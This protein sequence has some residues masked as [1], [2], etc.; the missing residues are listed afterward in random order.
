MSH[1]FY[2]DDDEQLLLKIRK[3]WL[4]LMLE[5]L[6]IKFAIIVPLIALLIFP[7]LL[8]GGAVQLVMMCLSA[9]LLLCIIGIAT[10]WTNY[11][12]DL[13][14]VT[15]KRIVSMEQITLFHREA[16]TMRMER[17]QD[18]TIE[19]PGFLSTFFNFG[20]LTVH[21]AGEHTKSQTFEG[22]PDPE[23]V[24]AVVLARIDAVTEHKSKLEY[25]EHENPN[26]G[27]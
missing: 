17:I 9:W 24:K 3:H 6:P 8:T 16:T 19:F 18:T 2:M 12:L 23:G 13:W 22:I 4:L 26:S 25:S 27:V 11:Y 5:L 20:N 14:I 15:D 1:D 10:V 21:T 7:S